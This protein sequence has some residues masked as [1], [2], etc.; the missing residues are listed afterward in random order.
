MRKVVLFCILLFAKF[1]LEFQINDGFHLK[2]SHSQ[3]RPKR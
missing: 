3:I 2:F 1:S